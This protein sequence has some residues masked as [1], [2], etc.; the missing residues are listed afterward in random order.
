[1]SPHSGDLNVLRCCLFPA[2][3]IIPWLVRNE[4]IIMLS[5]ALKYSRTLCKEELKLLTEFF[6]F[7]VI[8]IRLVGGR[9]VGAY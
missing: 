7:T 6:Y 8:E 1:M 2:D 9:L 5:L 3:V 4:I